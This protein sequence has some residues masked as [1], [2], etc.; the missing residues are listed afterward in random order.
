MADLSVAVWRPT[1]ILPLVVLRIGF[2]CLMFAGTLRFVA[3]GWVDAFF[4]QPEF[5]FTYWGLAWVRPLPGPW[6]YAAFGALALAA[7][8]VAAG[9]FY[10]FSIVAFFVL[11]TYIELLDKTYYLN[12]YYFVSLLSFLLIFLP[13][14]HWAALDV[15]RRPHTASPMVGAWAVGAVRLQIGL[16]YFLAGIAKIKPDWLF[17]AQPLRIWLSARTDFPLLGPLFDLA[18]MPYLMSWGGMLFDLTIPFLLLYRPTRIWAYCAVIGFHTVTGLLFPIGLF[19]LIMIV[20]TL[21]FF[22]ADELRQALL[23]VGIRIPGAHALTPAPVLSPVTQA[24]AGRPFPE[25]RVVPAPAGARPSPARPRARMAVP[26]LTLF[27]VGQLLVAFRHWYYPG[28]VLWTE[29]G[30]RYAWH[31]MLVEKTGHVTYWVED[32]AR[33]TVF[34]VYPSD[35][36]TYQQEKQMSFQPDMILEFAHY[37]AARLRAQGMA[38]VAIRA[39][40]YVSLNGRPSRLLIDPA[41]DLTRIPHNLAPKPWILPADVQDVITLGGA[42]SIAAP[43]Q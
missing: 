26:L 41:V 33:G 39:E 13:L 22:S 15:L 7:L 31:V 36:L 21:V 5:H 30:F 12:H 23:W 1:S 37:L 16:V 43:T 29:E 9:L 25:A 32:P 14:G 18:W 20:C 40:A 2:G 3:N 8:G 35:Y 4:L 11:F 42:A 34:P 10:R 38:N 6:L 24:P 17:E 27:F 28:D 19:P